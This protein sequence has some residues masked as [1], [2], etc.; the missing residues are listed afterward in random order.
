M[1][2]VVYVWSLMSALAPPNGPKT[3]GWR[4]KVYYALQKLWFSG[5]VTAW[6]PGEKKI[7]VLYDDGDVDAFRLC[8][9]SVKFLRLVE[10]DESVG[11]EVSKKC[12]FESR[13]N[14]HGT[15][16]RSRLAVP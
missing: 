4:V 8:D 3:V 5:R 10:K 15:F 1:T 16:D 12:S 7:E 6:L 13:E 14:G 9:F 11:Y 2:G